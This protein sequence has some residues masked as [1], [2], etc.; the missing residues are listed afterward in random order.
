[1]K[2]NGFVLVLLL[3]GLTGC[4]VDL[5]ALF[6][7]GGEG[8]GNP[9]D[10]PSS[11]SKRLVRF[12]SAEELGAYFAEQGTNSQTRGG[13]EVVF[14]EDVAADGAG[15]FDSSAAPTNGAGAE[16]VA[17]D[18]AGNGNGFSTTTEQEVGV[19]ESDVIKNDGEY[20]Y[21]LSRGNLRIVKAIPADALE[22][23]S[24]V[25]LKG[26]AFDMYLTGD[27]AVVITRPAF[28]SVA[29][30]NGTVEGGSVGSAPDDGGGV[31]TALIAS[32]FF[33]Y[34]PRVEVTVIDVSDRS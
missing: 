12:E 19:Q 15:D 11:T 33:F 10:D 21:V 13:G 34:K 8:T 22:E 17:A 29:V 14:A 24:S 28:D 3:V 20:L 18:D 23:M 31:R 9:T 4:D 26:F 25:D 16:T 5:M 6:G 2:K 27:K 1:M 32:D 30:E 7:R